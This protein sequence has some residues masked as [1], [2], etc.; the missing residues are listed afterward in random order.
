MPESD[1][2]ELSTTV[3]LSSGTW[4]ILVSLGGKLPAALTG[5][6]SDEQ[7]SA[8]TTMSRQ[9]M[10]DIQK[11]GREETKECKRAWSYGPK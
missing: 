3:G 10:M 9:S 2:R 5:V 8:A 6:A 4:E 11:E 1:H 7:Q